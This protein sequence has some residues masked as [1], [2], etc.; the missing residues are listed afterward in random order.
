MAVEIK[1]LIIK[2]IVNQGNSQ[3]DHDIVEIIK[4]QM[5]NYNFVISGIEKKEIIEECLMEMK[6][7]LERK[8]NL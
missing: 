1:E 3:S 2:G 4:N 7:I 5:K 8:S 6:S